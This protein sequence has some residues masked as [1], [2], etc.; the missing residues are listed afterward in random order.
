MTQKNYNNSTCLLLFNHYSQKIFKHPVKKTRLQNHH[1]SDISQHTNKVG[2]NVERGKIQVYFCSFVFLFLT[3]CNWN[4]LMLAVESLNHGATGAGEARGF[5]H[6]PLLYVRGSSGCITLQIH[7]D[8]LNLL[9]EIHL[10]PQRSFQWTNSTMQKT[11]PAGGS[12][13]GVLFS[14]EAAWVTHLRVVSLADAG[15]PVRFRLWT[16]GLTM[17]IT[18]QVFFRQAWPVI[19]PVSH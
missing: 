17:N 12:R 7:K 2:N 19:R 4:P 5:L 3:R 9:L 11:K 1:L 15:P 8:G 14:K 13:Q 16:S 10:S 6:S 18:K